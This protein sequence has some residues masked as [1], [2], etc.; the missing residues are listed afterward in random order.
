MGGGAPIETVI[1]IIV[2]GTPKPLERN[3]HRIITPKRRPA[4]VG[5]YLPAKSRNEQA[6]IRD[7]AA[8]AMNGRPPIEGPVDLRLAVYLPIA[9]SWSKKK[10]EAA[11]AGYIRPTAR[12]D[13][14]N[15]VKLA[16]DAAKSIVW[17]DDSQ[18]TDAAMWKRFS[19]TPRLVI[20]IRP[21]VLAAT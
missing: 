6:V 20:E 1:R 9:P 13:I 2:P 8:L 11:R 16:M 3:R 15:F 19:D 18:V 10:Q 17:R 4:F 5:N 21:I 12:P 14:D 7:F